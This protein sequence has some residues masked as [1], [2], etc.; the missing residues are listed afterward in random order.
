MGR[1]LFTKREVRCT[2]PE[3]GALNRVPGYSV[4]RAPQCGK[5]H[6]KLPEANA[7]RILRN[8]YGVRRFWL[9]I[10]ALAFLGWAILRPNSNIG[11]R[12]IIPASTPVASDACAGRAQPRQ[13]IYKWYGPTWGN[14][15]ANFTI[16]TAA[17]SNYFVKLEDLSG[18]PARAFFVHGGSSISNLVPL[19]TFVLKYAI[20]GSWC[21]EAE[22]FGSNTA[23]NQADRVLTFERKVTEDANWIT[24]RTNGITVELI[25]QP[26]GNLPTHA[27]PRSQF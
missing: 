13:G 10:P 19:G 9:A 24:T 4:R 26:G 1:T 3:C 17:G 27:I 25:L 16:T 5:C 23:T 20:G 21:G 12:S 18:R 6:T 8:L 14:D 22:L 7:V 15:V 2:N 11:D